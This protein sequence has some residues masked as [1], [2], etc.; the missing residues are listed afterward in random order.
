V[1]TNLKKNL[2]LCC[3]LVGISSSANSSDIKGWHFYQEPIVSIEEK[4]EPKE[5]LKEE[6]KKEEASVEKPK[7]QIVEIPKYIPAPKSW[8]EL[9]RE[10]SGSVEWM[11]QELKQLTQKAIEEPSEENMLEYALFQRAVADKSTVFS[12]KYAEIYQKY[13]QLKAGIPTSSVGL[14]AANES[15]DKT[16]RMNFDSLKDR[17]VFF[18]FFEGNCIYCHKMAKTTLAH[19]EQEGYA[20][21]AISTGNGGI[22]GTIYE[23]P[24]NYSIATKEQMDQLSL[25]VIPAIYM[26]NP[27]TKELAHLSLGYID[28]QTL[29][30]KA[31][32]VAKEMGLLSDDQY[33]KTKFSPEKNN[34]YKSADAPESGLEEN[35]SSQD[36]IQRLK[37]R[38]R[39]REESANNED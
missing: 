1:K 22:E 3:L 20:V 21:K 28:F 7:V 39:I 6:P 27:N 36:L 9:E 29:S 26:F 34:I 10:R 24:K 8:E 25:E 11:N 35:Y 37:Q 31:M 15:K 5:E 12:E 13:P 23:H 32:F 38:M 2:L 18:F 4:P 19:M 33:E 14:R 30:D 17:V 16:R